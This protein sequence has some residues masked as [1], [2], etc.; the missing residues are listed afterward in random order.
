MRELLLCFLAAICLS[1]QELMTGEGGRPPVLVQSDL[2]LL[3]SGEHRD[4]LGCT[5]RWSKPRLGFDLRY[6]LEFEVDIQLERVLSS[7]LLVI[8]RV[9][10]DG[11]PPVYFRQIWNK[12][13]EQ[14]PDVDLTQAIYRVTGGF[15]AGPGKYQA[16]WLLRDVQGNACFH[17]EKVNV[18]NSE[19]LQ[20]K[21]NQILPVLDQ[22][23]RQEMCRVDLA[24]ITTPPVHLYVNYA[25][26]VPGASAPSDQDREA[27]LSMIRLFTRDCSIPQLHL[28]VFDLERQQV[29]LKSETGRLDFS[30]LGESLSSAQH[31]TISVN[32]LNES[33]SAVSFVHAMVGTNPGATVFIGPAAAGLNTKVPGDETFADCQRCAYLHYEPSP[34]PDWVDAVGRWIRR[35]RGTKFEIRQ[36]GDLLRVF[37]QLSKI[38]RGDRAKPANDGHIRTLR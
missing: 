33:P 23:L 17:T 3:E 21:A 7:E 10:P 32:S 9:T 20:A 13:K 35:V 31:G 15:D 38:I 30:E 34:A 11:G 14:P 12:P 16:Q 2:A 8:L 37:P 29:L 4:D 19:G 26:S 27:I 5:V 18:P 36:P 24:E 25:S 6:H 22:E 1:G 28:T